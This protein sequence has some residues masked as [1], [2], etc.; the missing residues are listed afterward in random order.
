MGGV[1][2]HDRLCSTFSLCKCHGF[3]KYYVKLFLFLVGIALTNAWVYYKMS[4]E[5][6]C[7]KEG[8]QVRF[9]EELVEHMVNGKTNRQ[10]YE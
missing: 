3:K 7:R 9:F 2:C 1:D 10:E 5:E 4:N 8:A 6:S